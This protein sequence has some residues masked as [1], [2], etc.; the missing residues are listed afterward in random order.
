MNNLCVVVG[1]GHAGGRAVEAL[2]KYGFDGRIVLI[3]AE[4]ALPLE[5]PPLSKAYLANPEQALAPPIRDR[6]WYQDNDVE[7][8]LGVEA[9]ALNTETKTLDLA[10]GERLQWQSLILTTGGRVRRLPVAGDELDGIH[11]LRTLSDADSLAQALSEARRVVV[12]GGGFI[13]LEAASVAAKSCDVTVVEAGPSLMG[14]AVA[15]E[16]ATVVQ[17]RFDK[18]GINVM[19][20]ASAARFV[21]ENGKVTAVELV[22][23]S[24]LQ[25]DCVIV[26]VGIEPG[27]ELAEAAGI[28]V[29]NGIIVDEYCRTSATDVYAAGDVANHYSPIYDRHIRLESWQNAQNQAI[30]AARNV[31]GEP[32]P[33][34]EVPWFWSDQL[35]YKIQ[36]AGAAKEWDSIQKRGDGDPD[37]LLFQIRNSKVVGLQCIGALK[38]MRRAR[39]LLDN[40]HNIKS[41]DLTDTSIAMKDIVSAALKQLNKTAK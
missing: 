25:A 4:S 30:A 1:A 7:L 28:K 41:I 19:T 3:G 11:Y 5:R 9:V 38:D 21:G 2:R 26:G 33:Y 12:V 29:D 37:L 10:D 31:A 8:R 27:T 13:G 40:D 6:Q 35:D 18:A 32:A 22:D 24:S 15:S 34:S 17:Q 14:R 23:G 36:V 16:I 20:D 39:K